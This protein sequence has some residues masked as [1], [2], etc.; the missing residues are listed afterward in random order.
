MSWS[1]A[2]SYF[3]EKIAGYSSNVFTLSP[4]NQNNNITAN[5]ILTFNLPANSIVNLRS[6]SVHFNCT[7]AGPAARLPPDISSLFERV[8]VLAGGISLSQGTN[9]Y[10]VLAAAKR[11]LQGRGSSGVNSH[12]QMVRQTSYVD[13]SVILAAAPEVYPILNG[14]AQFCV[15][16][17]EGFLSSAEP[18]LL[19]LSLISDVQVKIY[20]ASNSVLTKGVGLVLGD[21]AA[22]GAATGPTGRGLTAAG[23]NNN[24]VPPAASS[25]YT[26][27]NLHAQ[28]ECISLSD[29]TYDSMLSEQ[30]NSVGWLEVPFL[31]YYGFNNAHGGAT[32]WS[33]ASQS[34]NKCYAVWRA[35]A[36]NTQASPLTIQGYKK[37]GA[38]V[39]AVAGG[40]LANIDVGRPQYDI[41]GVLST[42]SEKY[43]NNYF[44]FKSP[45]Q[46]VGGVI[47]D[48]RYQWTLNGANI[49]QSQQRDEDCFQTSMN[50][51]L[52][53][54]RLEEM[55]LDQYRQNYFV[56]CIRLNMPTHDYRLISGLDSRAVNLQGSYNTSGTI[57]PA[58]NQVT[59]FIE[60]TASLK[61]GAGRAIEI[62]H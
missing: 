5:D 51:E 17:F 16:H 54:N 60:C 12:P 56:Q 57:D 50:A 41:G 34:I 42:N 46:W 38:F 24:A 39:D 45:A 31:T 14:E 32:R 27:N 52:G 58:K 29:Q 59:L 3:I 8:E 49:P 44:N 40:V 23:F 20:L 2:L 35:A 47:S 53:Y 48:V 11:A 33:V 37:A 1:P 22:P 43:T 4:T 25:T 62:I 61:I 7:T 28:I 18:R 21:V 13:G 26:I 55:S 19:D 10:G 9:F 30:L 36:Y 6:F 15:S